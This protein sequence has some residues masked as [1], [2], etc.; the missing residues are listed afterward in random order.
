M[1]ALASGATGIWCGVSRE[2]AQ[3]GHASSIVTLMNLHRLGNKYVSERY[4]LAALRR[5]AI[6]VTRVT[7]GHEPAD[8]EEVY[9]PRSIEV[10]AQGCFKSA[11]VQRVNVSEAQLL[12]QRT[13]WCWAPLESV[14]ILTEACS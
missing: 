7:T 14:P 5:A 6:E 12:R 11:E 10:R 1:E 2:G 9:G 8:N 3:V 4:D 13:R